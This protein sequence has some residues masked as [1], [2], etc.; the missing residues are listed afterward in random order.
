LKRL[1]KLSR[2]VLFAYIAAVRDSSEI[3][4]Y[5]LTKIPINGAKNCGNVLDFVLIFSQNSMKSLSIFIVK[6]DLKTNNM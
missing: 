2:D 3:L 5:R 1:A 6:I 4:L